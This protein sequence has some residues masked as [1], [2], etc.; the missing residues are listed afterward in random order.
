MKSGERSCYTCLPTLMRCSRTWGKF[1]TMF[2]QFADTILHPTPLFF[3][4]TGNF[5]ISSGMDQGLLLTR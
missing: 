3:F 1:S 2:I 4:H 5:F